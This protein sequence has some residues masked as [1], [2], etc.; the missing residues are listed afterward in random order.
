MNNANAVRLCGG[1]TLCMGDK[2]IP[3]KVP[4]DVT[5]DLF[6]AGLIPD[7][8]FGLNHEK[9][10]WIIDTD[11]VYTTTFDL[12]SDLFRSEEILLQFDAVDTFSEIILN[13]T[14]LGK[15]DNMFL[16]YTFSVK[17]LLKDKGNTLQVRLTATKK[18]MDKI[19][20][21]GYFGVFNSKRL[22][23]R[24][25]QCH[26]GWDWA[27][28]MPGY[29]IC[30][31][32]RL[33][34]VYKNRIDNTCY[35]AANDGS[36]TLFTELN[37]TI[38][39]QIDFQGKLVSDTNKECR[40]DRLR[41]TVA[42]LP[43]RPLEEA[44]PLADECLITGKKNFRNFTLKDP[45]LWYPNGRGA[46]PL[47][48]YRVEL[49]RDGVVVDAECGRFA[50][51]EVK[52][53]QKPTGADTMGYSFCIN[54]ED[55]FIKGSNWVPVECFSGNN[56]SEKYRRLIRSAAEAGINM[57]RVWGGGI[58]EN[59]I[60]YDLCDE[61]GVLVWQDIM[62]ACADIPEDRESF[63]ENMRRE[64]TYQVK[65]LRNHPALV[66]WCGGN[67]KTGTYG[68]QISRGDYFVDVILRGLIGNLDDTRPYARQSPCSL[69]D[70]GNDRTSGESHAGS[71]ETTLLTTPLDYRKNVA[72]SLVPFVSECATMSIGSAESI[73]RIFPADK[74]WPP[75]E[76]WHDRLMNNPYSGV[77]MSF[78]DRQLYYAD[79][80]YGKSGSL[81][82]FAV[83][84]MTVH[85]ET[86]RA[87]IE[88]ARFNRARC[89]G[90]MNWMYSDIWPS[91]TWSVVDYDG[92]AK[93]AYY[94]MK[95][96]YAPLLLTFVQTTEG[97]RLALINDTPDAVCTRVRYGL[98]DVCGRVLWS[99]EA[100]A[101]AAPRTVWSKL[102]TD[103]FAKEDTYLFAEAECGGKPISAVYSYDM[104][105]TFGATDDYTVSTAP[106]DDG[107][108][109]TV[110]A[111]KFVRGVIIRMPENFRYTYSDNYFDLQAGET[112]TVLIRGA[113]P[114]DMPE[115]TD[116]T[117]ETRHEG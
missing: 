87:E 36:L 21:T 86:L 37:Y 108:S 102:V 26:F 116:F 18:V 109:V 75:N 95:R 4:G 14:S 106:A 40:G 53:V 42:T 107:L 99:R 73:A 51:R 39:P 6:A 93:A 91:A 81:A 43:D 60:F 49:I 3:A 104:W 55:T 44:E 80:L 2:T 66:Y 12:P 24:K 98:K 88:F 97:T 70:I 15:T 31:E 17:E 101:A 7:P 113:R 23:I 19:D 9:L 20:D 64:V 112:K 10:G 114:G 27:P 84:S 117:K 110:T 69:T 13:G 38:R 50:F 62:L 90:F 54:G 8:Y 30:G 32:V 94:Q 65:R 35:H 52:L 96:S 71:Y 29:G 83:K 47:Y 115:V 11:F 74:L 34:G 5:T 105:H 85:A 82:E 78:V 100:D 61:E 57:L 63:V 111:K 92:E 25:A 1:W 46:H 103:D 72:Q 77:D 79:G 48:A 76:Y 45:Q 16:Q 22:F 89:G 41:Y 33:R 59:D 68:L 67:E 56:T 28:D 58:Y